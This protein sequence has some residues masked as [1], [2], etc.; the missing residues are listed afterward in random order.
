LADNEETGT[1]VIIGGLLFAG[2]MAVKA[3]LGYLRSPQGSALRDALEILLIG[4]T[5]IVAILWQAYLIRG[6]QGQIPKRLIVPWGVGSAMFVGVFL[7]GAIRLYDGHLLEF[8][9][10][11]LLS[12]L[13][14]VVI[15]T[16]ALTIKTYLGPVFLGAT[17]V[18][19]VYSGFELGHL[20][21]TRWVLGIINLVLPGLPEYVGVVYVATAVTVAFGACTWDSV[22]H[23]TDSGWWF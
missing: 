11:T 9:V 12:E 1:V 5:T 4:G 6:D 2:Y 18:Q 14:I 13:F 23:L 3:A 22:T 17:L 8:G 21:V 16:I 19:L 7:R 20:I 10:G 15:V